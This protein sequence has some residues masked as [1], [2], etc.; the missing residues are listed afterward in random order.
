MNYP[1]ALAKING[2]AA[3]TQKGWDSYNAEPV[4]QIAINTAIALAGTCDRAGQMPDD[5]VPTP[6][7]GVQFEYKSLLLGL[8]SELEIFPNGLLELWMHDDAIQ[9][10]YTLRLRHLEIVD[11]HTC[12][13]DTME[14]APYTQEMRFGW[15][16]V[17]CKVCGKRE[18]KP[19]GEPWREDGL[20]L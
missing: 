12:S 19:I 10:E 15:E 9:H 11:P 7:G 13:R 18:G 17:Q 14:P 8:E 4:S 6:K 3:L 2:F 20:Y 16:P 1:E 5:I